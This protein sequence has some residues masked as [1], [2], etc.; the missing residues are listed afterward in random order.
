MRVASIACKFRQM[1]R[2][3]SQ[4]PGTP[5]WKFGTDFNNVFLPCL[6]HNKFNSSLRGEKFF[7]LLKG[8]VCRKRT[9]EDMGETMG[10][11]FMIMSSKKTVLILLA[12]STHVRLKKGSIYST[13]AFR[14]FRSLTVALIYSAN[15]CQAQSPRPRAPDPEPQ[16]QAQTLFLHCS[17]FSNSSHFFV[18]ELTKN[19]DSFK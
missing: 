13:F 19:S 10:Q 4:A 5:H 14:L 17:G 1:D 7:F 15:F 6:F 11:K 8:W 3:S 16:T 18:L 9:S 12:Q 2:L